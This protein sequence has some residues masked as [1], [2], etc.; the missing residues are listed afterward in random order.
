MLIDIGET[1][2]LTGRV[3]EAAIAVHRKLG[4]G[5][6]HSA[7]RRCLAHE[8]RQAGM[9]VQEE[10]SLPL[11]YGTLQIANAFVIDLLVNDTV[12][13]EIKCVRALAPVHTSQLL[14]YL[15][16]TQR[17]VGLLINF[18]VP[19]LKQGLRRVLNLPRSPDAPRREDGAP[20][21]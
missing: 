8:L 21:I 7:Y 15:R 9:K 14:T 18:H 19:V 13:V 2:A 1:G 3:I 11:V 5:L 10:L 4:P 12:I 20:E 16:L 17:K 6:L